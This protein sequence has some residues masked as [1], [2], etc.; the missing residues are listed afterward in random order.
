M[1]KA[2]SISSGRNIQSVSPEP[3]RVLNEAQK[4][5]AISIEVS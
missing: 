2:A 4:K 1:G 3:G 5:A